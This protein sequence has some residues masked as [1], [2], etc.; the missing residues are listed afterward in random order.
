MEKKKTNWPIVANSFL[1]SFDYG[2]FKAVLTSPDAQYCRHISQ[3]KHSPLI[4]RE[5]MDA[6]QV[7]G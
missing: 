6:K 4:S 3:M 1:L 5:L 7:I 2:V